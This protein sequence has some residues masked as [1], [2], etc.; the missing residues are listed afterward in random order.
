MIGFSPDGGVQPGWVTPTTALS[1]SAVSRSLDILSNGVTQLSW[2]EYRGNLKL[3]SSRLVLEPTSW[4]TRREWTDRVVRTLALFDICY[5]LKVGGT[6]AEGVPLGLWPI[7][8]TLISPTLVDN[9]SLIP[10]QQFRIGYEVVERDELVILH[11]TS[12]PTII[13]GMASILILARAAFAAA[14][15]ADRYASR[16]WQGGGSPTTVLT[17]PAHMGQTEADQN[18]ARWAERR[19]RGPDYVPVLSGGLDAKPFGADLTQQAAVE[20]RKEQV[21]DVGRYFGIP[22][23]MLNAPAGDSETYATTEQQGIH[24]AR[25]T[26]ADY[27]GAVQDG[28]T[29][30]LPG[31]RYMRMDDWPLT[32]GTAITRAQTW[33]LATGGLPWMDTDEVRDR[34]GLPPREIAPPRAAA[35]VTPLPAGGSNGNQQ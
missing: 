13:E 6:D 20:A 34:E 27:I 9:Y 33:Q 19:R 28:I 26:L 1:L 10:P 16:F 32:A 31:G 5:L 15:S 24:L 30:E 4:M 3:P 8:P 17:T 7:D 35:P 14:I 11:R 29:G 23:A 18:A 25:Y 12:T 21:A 2:G 22:T